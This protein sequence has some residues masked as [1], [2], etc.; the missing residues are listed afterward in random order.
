FPLFLPFLL[1]FLIDTQLRF[2]VF[3]DSVNHEI[4]PL[5]RSTCSDHRRRAQLLITVIMESNGW[6]PFPNQLYPPLLFTLR[7][8]TPFLRFSSVLSTRYYPTRIA[9]GMQCVAFQ[10]RLRHIQDPS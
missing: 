3:R 7:S 8:S 6:C 5:W 1:E 9:A 4:A 10:Y 2:C